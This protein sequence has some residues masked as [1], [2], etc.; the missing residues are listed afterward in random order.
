MISAA[1]ASSIQ[2]P[3]EQPT[4]SI[5]NKTFW[6]CYLANALLVTANAMTFH[7]VD[8]VHFL[9]GNDQITG[10]IMSVGLIAAIVARLP[11]GRYIDLLGTQRIWVGCSFSFLFGCVGMVY[12]TDINWQIYVARMMYAVG[13]AG[14]FTAA[15]VFI[16]NQ[17]PAERRTEVIGSLGSS[18]FIGMAAGSLFADLVLY[19]VPINCGVYSLLFSMVGMVGMAYL[20][21]VF[22]L[23]RGI[24]HEKPHESLP[25]IKLILRYWPGMVLLVAIMMGGNMA[26]TGGFLASYVKARG[27]IGIAPFFF[28]YAVSAFTFRI[29]TR[30][31]GRIIGRHRMILCGLAG[32][33]IGH[34]ALP[35][36]TESWQL[37]LPS[38]ACGFGHAL[39]FPAVV[40]LGAGAFPPRY[41]GLGTTLILG[42][43]ELGFAIFAP[44]LGTIIDHIGFQTMFFT[45]SILTVIVAITYQLTAAKIGDHEQQQKEDSNSKTSTDGIIDSEEIEDPAMV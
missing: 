31:W 40:S 10:T 4:A 38:I 3:L 45:S 7:F 14:M 2:T 1:P 6:L 24:S 39:L 8:F 12:V 15:I 32:Q 25:V 19:L 30:H 23:T 18:G 22:Y 43:S 36:L 20:G 37:L 5:Y 9:K 28:G 33:A 13:I 35:F 41:R 34:F 29:L 42:F 21:I 11:L 16:Q 17:V 26:V 27:F 44:I